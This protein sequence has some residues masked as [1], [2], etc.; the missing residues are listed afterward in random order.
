[1]QTLAQGLAMF[2]MAFYGKPIVYRTTDF[3]S[4]EYRNLLGGSLFENHEDNP[5]LGYRGVS[6][7][8]H[9]WEL[10]AFKLARS[11]DSKER[12]A[13]LELSLGRTAGLFG[14]MRG[15]INALE[16]LVLANAARLSDASRRSF[17]G[18]FIIAFKNGEKINVN[19][20]IREFKNNR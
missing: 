20:G 2:A 18:A 10:E 16:E 1:M 13:A 4:N 15:K 6:R 17:N 9:D 19:A 3:K 14:D 12:A 7:N 11:H 5:M 8:I